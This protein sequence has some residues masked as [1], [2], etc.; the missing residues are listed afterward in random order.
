MK[1]A[2]VLAIALLI[3]AAPALADI[4]H[5]NG[6]GKIEG[7]V[8]D[9]G[10]KLE[11][12]HRYGKMIVPKYKVKN[13]EKKTTLKEEYE[14]KLK[15]IDRKDADARVALGRWLAEKGWGSQSLKEY[16]TALEI[17]A[18][19]RGAHTALGHVFYEGKWRT[20]SEI[21]ELRGFVRVGGDWLTKEE[22]ARHK[23]L[24][25]RKKALKDYQK[26]E[27]AFRRKLQSLIRDI[28]YG[29]KRRCDSAHKELVTIAREKKIAG[30][31]KFAGDV[32]AYF[33]RYWTVVRERQNALTEVR[34]TMTKLKRPIPKFTTSL[35]ASTTPVTLQLPELA[36][37]SIKTTVIIPAG[38]GLPEPASR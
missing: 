18:N 19:H 17:D 4:V 30:L 34:A 9:L 38:R 16:A 2:L 29:S 28:A 12:E 21:M 22:A 35:G 20:E 27:R 11:I 7:K 13:V 26:A 32:K 5:L 8:T 24:A 6:G 37:V 31:E 36:V 14:A 15:K 3:C 25:E 1:T 10:D 23:A 33:D